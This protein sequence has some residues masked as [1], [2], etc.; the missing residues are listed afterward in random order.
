MKALL[1]FLFAVALLC[2]AAAEGAYKFLD[3]IPI[4]GEGNWD[5]V[6]ID[7]AARRL[8]LSHATKVVIVDLRNTV[9]PSGSP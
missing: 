1:G 5:L 3:E 6:A 9:L 2:E 8:Y 7:A 4:G